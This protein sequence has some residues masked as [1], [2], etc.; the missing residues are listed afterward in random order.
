MTCNL[1]YPMSLRHP[2][3]SRSP[4]RFP[5]SKSPHIA[6]QNEDFYYTFTPP[7]FRHL[8]SPCCTLSLSFVCVSHITIHSLSLSLSVSFSLSLP[9]FLFI[10][11]FLSLSLSF[12]HILS[13]SLSL[14]LLNPFLSLSLSL[15]ISLSFSS[16]PS[17]SYYLLLSFPLT[18]SFD[19]I[20]LYIYINIWIY[21]LS[22]FC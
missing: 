10:S 4:N 13:H 18:S 12:Y 22:S 9:F 15:S 20:P 16:P 1:R 3:V 21:S 5:T 8:H 14:S 2:V 17:L 6:Y 11:L 19:S 7:L